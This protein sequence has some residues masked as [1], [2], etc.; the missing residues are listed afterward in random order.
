MSISLTIKSIVLTMAYKAYILCSLN[1]YY[2]VLSISHTGS[3]SI[4]WWSKHS[5]TPGSLHILPTDIHMACSFTLFRFVPKCHLIRKA[6][7]DYPILYKI[8]PLYQSLFPY[9]AL[10]FFIVGI[11]IWRIIHIVIYLYKFIYINGVWHIWCLTHSRHLI[12]ICLMN[13]SS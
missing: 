12:N 6:F 11:T 1:L 7:P 3:L 13:I 2:Y 9:P 8:A 5:T 10:F 4:P